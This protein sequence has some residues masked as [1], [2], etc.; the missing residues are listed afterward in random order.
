MTVFSRLCWLIDWD[1]KRKS[2]NSAG[3]LTLLVGLTPWLLLSVTDQRPNG[4]SVS[5]PLIIGLIFDALWFGVVGWR[6]WL[7]FRRSAAKSDRLYDQKG[8]YMLPPEYADTE[9]ATGA[10][11]RKR[12]PRSL[13]SSSI[14]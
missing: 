10:R 4:S 13:P 1:L 2:A 12:N 5:V 9:S 3:H 11:R 6:A 8:K 7:L 14:D